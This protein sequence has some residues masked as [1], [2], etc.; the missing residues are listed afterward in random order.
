MLYKISNEDERGAVIRTLQAIK[1]TSTK[2]LDSKAMFEFMEGVKMDAAE[3]GVELPDPNTRGYDE[4]RGYY[5][6][7]TKSGKS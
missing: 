4:M 6:F 2:T 5:D 7:L 1:L 3:I